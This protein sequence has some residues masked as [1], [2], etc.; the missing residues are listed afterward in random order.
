MCNAPVERKAKT[1]PIPRFCSDKCRA[2]DWAVR[3]PDK[4]AA[5][6]KKYKET[7]QTPEGK[8]KQRESSRLRRLEDP[9]WFSNHFWL[10]KKFWADYL[11]GKCLTCSETRLP[12]LDFDHRDPAQKEYSISTVFRHPGKYSAEVVK[13]E[14][15]KCD[16]LCSNCHRIKTAKHWETVSQRWAADDETSSESSGVL[17]ASR[18]LSLAYA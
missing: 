7:K 1:G 4:V 18:Q 14:V 5:G 13:A 17:T 11:G 8:N 6:A 16:L 10:R 3:N 2:A 15:D 12:C 9:H